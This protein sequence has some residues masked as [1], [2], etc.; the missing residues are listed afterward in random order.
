M[1]H[2]KLHIPINLSLDEVKDYELNN[3][4]ISKIQ[5]LEKYK[6][7]SIVDLFKNYFSN[8]ISEIIKKKLYCF[9][10]EI[11]PII[12]VSKYKKEGLYQLLRFTNEIAFNFPFLDALTMHKFV[13][14][15][16]SKV[17]LFSGYVTNLVTENIKIL[18]ILQPEYAVRL[19]G[20][21]SFY[22]I[23]FDKIN[24]NILNEEELLDALRQNHRLLKFQILFALINKEI[25]IERASKEFS[26]LAQATFDIAL[27]IVEEQVSKK[28]QIDNLKFS[29]IAYGRFAN[30]TMTSNS[31]LDLVFVYDEVKSNEKSMRSVYIELFR[32]LIKVLSAKTTKGFMYEV[33]TK[34]KP[35]GK[36]GPVACTYE[37]FKDY[38]QNRSFSWE[39]LALRKTRVINQNDLS[40][41][42]SELLKRLIT[43]P[44]TEKN[45]AN[46]INMMRTNINEAGG[47]VTKKEPFKWFETKYVGGGQRDIEFLNFF[48]YK[49]PKSID[50]H[51]IEKKI[52]LNK[53]M[54][55][56]YFNLD[57]IV[58]I[59]FLEEKQNSLPSNAVALIISE[60]N[61]KDLGSLKAAVNLGKSEI[62]KNL[63]QIVE[64]CKS[65]KV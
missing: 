4:I 44:I 51:E 39:K 36:K 54:Q 27:K 65:Y 38:H 41:K 24:I 45:M 13:Y 10:D 2:K 8:K 48:Y 25:N 11:I 16:L 40:L 18:D 31:D 50:Q 6:L 59:S 55:K 7:S 43:I 62:Y 33:D 29:I 46:E 64:S 28:Y 37:N 5:N 56:L 47:Q 49:N 21:I 15:N 23:M 20:N 9:F 60:V 19:N 26:L 30:H 34:L 12:F 58:N 32:Q 52:L 42:T 1:L 35:S 14:K 3:E 17:F 61:Q 53:K 57:Q 22:K 63:N